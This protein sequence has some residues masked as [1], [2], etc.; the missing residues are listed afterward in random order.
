MATFNNNFYGGYTLRIDYT[1]NSQ[2]VA[3]NTT[4][5]TVKAQLVSSGSSW[6]INSSTSRTGTLTINGTSY[7]F[8]C[9]VGITGGATKTLFTKTVD[10]PHNADGT[11][12]CSM[13]LTV[14]MN[15]TLSGTY[16]GTQTVSGNATFT[17]IPRKT[18]ISISGA[19]YKFGSAITISHA[20]ASTAFTITLRYTCGSKSGTIT[21]KAATNST[22]W[23]PPLSL[24]SEIPKAKS[25]LITIYCDTYNGSTLIGTTSTSYTC[26]I[27]DSCVPSITGGS[28]S[29]PDT[30]GTTYWQSVSCVRAEFTVSLAYGATISKWEM[31]VE[32]QTKVNYGYIIWS[33]TFTGSGNKDI[34]LTV[35]DSRGRTAT[36]TW[37]S[38]IYV[39]PYSKPNI[40]LFTCKRT[41]INED[42]GEEEISNLGTIGY[43]SASGTF[44]TNSTNQTRT[45]Q[46]KPTA[47]SSW[48]TINLSNQNYTDYKFSSALSS[49]SG[50]DLRLTLS[51][52][53]SS[54]TKDISMA[55]LFPLINLSSDGTAIAFG[56]EVVTANRFAVEMDATF[57]K[58]CGI[59]T[60]EVMGDTLMHGA[61]NLKGLLKM[62]YKRVLSVTD[63]EIYVNSSKDFPGMTM[64][65]S[66]TLRDR[67]DNLALFRIV[68]SGDGN[69]VGDG[70]TL[71]GYYQSE[72]GGYGHY[73]RGNGKM[74][75]NCKYGLTA[76]GNIA[77]SAK[78]YSNSIAYNGTG[79]W[80]DENG[81]QT[82]GVGCDHH[83][84][85]VYS[86]RYLGTSAHRWQQLYCVSSP[87]VSSDARM[88][89]NVKYM[90]DKP[91]ILN[92]LTDVKDNDE[93]TTKDLLDFVL[94]DLYM[95]TFDYKQNT[96]GMEE[97]EVQQVTA[98]NNRQ[99]G[100]IA[101]DIENTKVGRYLVTKDSEGIL[102]YESSNWPS[103]IA[104]AL[105]QEIRDRQAADKE[106]MDILNSIINE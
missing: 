48:T 105:Q 70:N 14:P 68:T 4:N 106:L 83:F 28:F 91:E 12:T 6:I 11:K 30:G 89:E 10:I 16:Y 40:S 69:G 72:N 47:S 55:N 63:S 58:W 82:W 80:I 66:M 51:D 84:L 87:S 13:K 45:F 44:H 100:F 86:T 34:K 43:F 33:H 99:I 56:K 41:G 24:Q 17:T 21:S 95:V 22:S 32:N 46:Y 9:N 92:E 20:R 18:S 23:T 90:Y 81:S 19:S 35:T 29:N 67:G 78:L 101:Q 26:Y 49:G 2:S 103:I 52:N 96:E 75:V 15:V 64:F 5:V 94:N 8:T 97:G 37:T 77:T 62:N 98:M 79:G 42:T 25:I 73:F 102:S 53:V 61:L 1:V 36:K 60:L 59:N 31:T 76:T 88:K 74:H 93:I 50:Y 3:N 104:G 65:G 71:L 27:A 7:T 38:A 57:G 85:P 39:T 54:T